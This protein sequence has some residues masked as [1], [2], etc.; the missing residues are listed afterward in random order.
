MRP[1]E[2]DLEA[3]RRMLLQSDTPAKPSAQRKQQVQD[4]RA[5]RDR[6]TALRAELRKCE[7]R[8]EKLSGMSEKLV[9]KLADPSLYEDGRADEAAVWQKKYAELREAQERAEELWVRAQ[10]RLDRAEG[11]EA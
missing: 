5:D 2:D 3:Y 1:Y 11:R 7:E 10:E 9:A 8:L 4:A 6:V